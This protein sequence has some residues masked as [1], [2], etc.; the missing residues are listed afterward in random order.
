N[1]DS[2]ASNTGIADDENG[3]CDRFSEDVD[4]DDDDDDDDDKIRDVIAVGIDVFVVAKVML[5][6][7]SVEISGIVDIF[8]VV[9][10]IASE[11]TEGVKVEIFHINDFSLISLLNTAFEISDLTD[12]SVL[13]ATVIV[14]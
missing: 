6:R 11:V 10:V 1:G 13:L 12:E 3:I 7:I 8:V 2:D 9:A 14:D 4:D 5:E